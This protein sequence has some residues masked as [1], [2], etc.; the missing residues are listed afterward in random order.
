M[1]P[2]GTLANRRAERQ[3]TPVNQWHKTKPGPEGPGSSFAM[4]LL[5]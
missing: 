4:G 1:L 5:S 3:S 2:R